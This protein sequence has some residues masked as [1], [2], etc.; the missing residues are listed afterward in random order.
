MFQLKGYQT[1]AVEAMRSFLTQCHDTDTVAQAYQAVLTE[2]K[3]RVNY[4]LGFLEVTEQYLIRWLDKELRQS[5]VLQQQLTAFI[6]KVIKNLLQQKRLTVTVLVRNKFAL[7]RATRD[8]IQRYRLQA[9]KESYQQ[10]LFDDDNSACISS[11]FYYRFQPNHY[12]SRSLS[13]L[14]VRSKG[15]SDFRQ[16]FRFCE[17]N[18]QLFNEKSGEND[19]TR[20]FRSRIVVS[21]TDFWQRLQFDENQCNSWLKPFLGSKVW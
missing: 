11:E 1:R 13:D 8:L 2:Q 9:Q 16:F 10:T 18:S 3:D 20:L 12:P 19:Q 14:P 15:K 5:D 4:N 6:A 7:A 17:E 21:Q